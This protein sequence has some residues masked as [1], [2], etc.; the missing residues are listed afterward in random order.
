MLNRGLLLTGAFWACLAMTGCADTAS[1]PGT[2]AQ[3]TANLDDAKDDPKCQED[4][5]TGSAI[6]KATTCIDPN[7]SGADSARAM[8]GPPGAK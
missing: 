8:V 6:H 7:S 2:T 4:T 1:A 5:V 3:K